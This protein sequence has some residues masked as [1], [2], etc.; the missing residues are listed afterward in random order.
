[1]NAGII[2]I[3]DELLIGQTLDTN[4]QWLSKRLFE[5]GI[6]LKEKRTIGD[7]PEAIKQA[8]R[9]MW[10]NCDVIL[11]TGGLGPT[12]DD[13]TKYAICDLFDDKLIFADDIFESLTEKLGRFKS[14]VTDSHRIQCF[15]P[16]KAKLLINN[17]GTAPAIW[18]NEKGR[19]LIAM[20]GVPFE[21]KHLFTEQILPN[22]LPKRD[23]LYSHTI[24]TGG[25]GEAAIER[26]IRSIEDSLPSHITLSY[27]P[28]MSQVRL[29]LTGHDKSKDILKT[30]MTPFINLISE[31]LDS[32]IVHE[33]STLEKELGKLLLSKNLKIGTAESCT[34]GY[35]SHQITSVP[36]SSS[37]YEGSI[38]SYSNEIKSNILNID[39]N[40]I[41]SHGAVSQ[42][43]VEKMVAGLVS[44]LNTDIGVAVSG[45]MG[46]GG[47][48]KEKPLGLVWIACGTES[49][50]Y[51]S[52]FNFTK[53]RI[54]NIKYT[55]SVAINM[56]RKFIL[57]H[58][59]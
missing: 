40:I 44:M 56:V 45:I 29:R 21:M 20:P 58:F 54:T 39:P 12:Q 55:S 28:G 23:D 51:S 14:P 10:E 5:I 25:E 8:C 19:Q 17:Y 49:H 18:M 13:A 43:V 1:M 34:G 9:E 7:K 30:E 16:S 53:D 15:L 48:T 33:D 52:S 2:A 41:K 22:V 26:K 38:I 46:P 37:Y 35:L 57:K 11:T 42:E 50:I 31:K 4:S 3:G 36:G 32:I 47:G 27:L 59:P 6:D 24:L